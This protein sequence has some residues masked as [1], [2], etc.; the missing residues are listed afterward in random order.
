MTKHIR[1]EHEITGI[2]FDEFVTI[3]PRL[4]FEELQ[5]PHPSNHCRKYY[6]G[7]QKLLTGL[8]A[9]I[10]VHQSLK[11]IPTSLGVH[12]KNWY[13]LGLS[14]IKRSPPCLTS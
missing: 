12:F 1:P 2:L 11:G 5:K 4:E 6:T 8:I 14:D 7:S 13:H 9:Q 10:S 3:I